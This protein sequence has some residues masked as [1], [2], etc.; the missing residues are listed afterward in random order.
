M[1]ASRFFKLVLFD[2]DGV[3]VDVSQ[4]YRR[5]IEETVEHFTGHQIPT[6]T[7]QRYKNQGGFNDD[8]KLTHAIIHTTGIETPLSRVIEEFT[9]RYRGDHWDDGFIAQEE[10]LVDAKT[11]DALCD[12]GAIMGVV[13]GRPRAEARWTIQHQG[14]KKYFPLVVDKEKQAGREKPDP[15]P[16]NHALSLLKAVGRPVAPE[17][18]L[19]VGDTVDDMKAARAAGAYAL[20]FVPPYAAAE[21]MAPVLE[22]AGAHLV[23]PEPSKLL[24][25]IERFHQLISAGE[26]EEAVPTPRAA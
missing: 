9:K 4:S 6:G 16:I 5:V 12:A 20:G 10:A 14:W 24:E 1:A 19:Y 7:V 11:L 23:C 13:T 26:A 17:A 18:T 8:W 22:K 3:L 15:Y 21:E 2:M 25:Y